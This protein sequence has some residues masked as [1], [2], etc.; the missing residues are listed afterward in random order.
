M[1]LI[2]V[3]EIKDLL[4][5]SCHVKVEQ[6]VQ[7]VWCLMRAMTKEKGLWL[8]REFK[9]YCIVKKLLEIL[10]MKCLVY[11]DT[12]VRIVESVLFMHEVVLE[13]ATS[14]GEMISMD[15]SISGIMNILTETS[16]AN[17]E[18]NTR[19]LKASVKLVQIWVNHSPHNVMCNFVEKGL[20]LA[21]TTCFSNHAKHNMVNLTSLWICLRRLRCKG[22]IS[23]VNASVY[24]AILRMLQSENADIQGLAIAFLKE[25]DM[26]AEAFF[27]STYLCPIGRGL[28]QDPVIDSEGHTFE[29]TNI[30]QWLE[31]KHVSPITRLPCD[32]QE[33][34]PNRALKDAIGDHLQ[35]LT[36]GLIEFETKF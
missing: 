29:R 13:N 32:P 1:S 9:N 16:I 23:I 5:S 7:L 27:P 28:M 8:N 22:H 19:A 34:R 21:L 25:I 15:W 35:L 14:L 24:Y 18:I 3:S 20:A 4:C 36:K 30:V 26:Y 31:Q 10:G 6:T 12:R 17:E 11:D 33:L 2:N